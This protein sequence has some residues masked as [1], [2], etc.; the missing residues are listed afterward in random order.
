MKLLTPQGRDNIMYL[1][2]LDYII[3]IPKNPKSEILENKYL[4]ALSLALE[5]TNFMD[6]KIPE[7]VFAHS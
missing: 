7:V 1:L 2:C 3:R 5:K 4:N 6:I